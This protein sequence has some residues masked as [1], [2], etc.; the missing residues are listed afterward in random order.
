MHHTWIRLFFGIVLC[1]PVTAA[2]ED[3]KSATMDQQQPEEN[4]AFRNCVLK[5]ASWEKKCLQALNDDDPLRDVFQSPY[6]DMFTNE[7]AMTWPKRGIWSPTP[8]ELF[9]KRHF[10]DIRD[11]EKIS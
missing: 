11:P 9:R 1:F 8:A 6:H 5:E 3:G 7:R 10:P 2:A 4:T